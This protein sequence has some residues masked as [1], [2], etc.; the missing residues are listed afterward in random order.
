MRGPIARHT[1][2]RSPGLL[3]QGVKALAF[4]V[5]AALVA[6]VGVGAYAYTDFTSTLRGNSITLEGQ[7]T[8][9]PDVDVLPNEAVNILVTGIDKCEA[10]L[11]DDFGGRCTEAMAKEQESS[12]ASQLN[13]VNMVVH[14]SP[15]PRHVTVIQIPRDMMTSRPACTDEDGNA[16]SP[17]A[18]AQFNEA[19]A[20]G[21][22]DCVAKTAAE[23]TGLDIDHAALMTWGGVIDITNA[24]GG[25]DVCV[26]NDIEDREHTG[27]VLDAGEHTLAGMSALQ[28]LRV[29]ESI[30]DGSDLARIGNQQVYMGALVRKL[31]SNETL[32]DVG[33]LLRLSRAV[34]DNATL[35]SGLTNDPMALVSIASA[36]SGVPTQEYAFIQ[37]PALDY[38]ADP[39][40]V[41]QDEASWAQIFEAL[42]AN[43]PIIVEEEPE[44]GATD[45]PT[46]DPTVEP[47]GSPT[48]NP[49]EIPLPSNLSGSNADDEIDC[50]SQEVLF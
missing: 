35:S 50:G 38:P 44:P 32:S 9:P 26:A 41:I 7:D 11:L 47:T 22:V 49:T 29:R 18:I 6:V 2:L 10:D 28:F 34:V 43:Q 36:L 30:G 3:L 40:R 39:N 27:L 20:T 48:P 23:L 46:P 33:A 8:D 31:V 14:I 12:F 19:Y 25:V 21:G 37:M 16:T 17:V 42:A 5:S 45:E 24:I 1:K 13:D 4:L 15:E